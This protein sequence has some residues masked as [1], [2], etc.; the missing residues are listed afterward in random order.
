MQLDKLTYLELFNTLA[1]QADRMQFNPY[2]MLVLDCMQLIFRCIKP[3]QL[4]KDPERAPV[5]NLAELL[6]GEKRQRVIA[7]QHKGS[8]HSRFGT[9][10]S[11]RAV[12]FRATGLQLT[13]R[14][15]R[16]LSFTRRTRSLRMS[17]RRWTTTSANERRG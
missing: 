14:T 8:R 7:L 5:E 10:L 12:S 9:T 3:E 13:D 11:A 4:V 6:E 1:S 15:D 16:G 17:A 2:N